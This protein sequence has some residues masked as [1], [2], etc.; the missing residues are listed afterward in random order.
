MKPTFL[1]FLMNIDFRRM[2]KGRKKMRE[3]GGLGW[4]TESSNSNQVKRKDILPQSFFN[5]L[6]ENAGPASLWLL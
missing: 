3:D 1:S 2:C 4:K 5:G 6:R